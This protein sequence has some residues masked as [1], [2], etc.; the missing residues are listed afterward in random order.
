MGGKLFADCFYECMFWF[1]LAILGA[2]GFWEFA[3]WLFRGP[4][5]QPAERKA[6]ISDDEWENL[7]EEERNYLRWFFK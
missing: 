2:L 5:E 3:E 7:S 6:T 1:L 4:P